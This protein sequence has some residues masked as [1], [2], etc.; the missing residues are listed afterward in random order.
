MVG[1]EIFQENNPSSKWVIFTASQ[2]LVRWSH[3]KGIKNHAET[4]YLE[5]SHA[6]CELCLVKSQKMQWLFSKYI[7]FSKENKTVF[8]GEMAFSVSQQIEMTINLSLWPETS[9]KL[10]MVYKMTKK[11]KLN[12][13]SFLVTVL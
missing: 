1:V 9:W 3:E 5:V 8:W 4:V 10:L 12:K 7:L 11:P 6:H 13:K 2:E